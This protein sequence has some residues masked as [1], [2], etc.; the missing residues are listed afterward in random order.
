MDALYKNFSEISGIPVEQ[1]P[2][3][4]EKLTRE[5]LLFQHGRMTKSDYFARM[6]ALLETSPTDE[7]L[8]RA[9][10]NMFS[11]NADVYN[12]KK[13]L[14]GKYQFSIISN[15][16]ELHFNYIM[17]KYDDFKVFH[18]NTT[19]FEENCMKPEKYI[20]EQALAKNNA[21]PEKSVF[22]DDLEENVKSAQEMGFKAIQYKSPKELKKELIE[23]DLF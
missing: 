5:Y 10:C 14:N 19:S 15:T 3:T 1:I 8:E 20:Y 12:I 13:E 11:F 4:L 22:I 21:E 16:D 7:K 17:N 6:R 23:L 9:Y 18:N 2:E